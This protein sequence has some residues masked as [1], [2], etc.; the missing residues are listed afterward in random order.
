MKTKLIISLLI[1]LCVACQS[2]DDNPT[3]PATQTSSILIENQQVSGTIETKGNVDWYQYRTRRANSLLHIQCTNNTLRPDTELLVTAYKKNPDNTY[4]RLYADHAPENSVLPTNIQMSL[5]VKHPQDIYLAVRDYMDDDTSI[6][7]YYLKVSESEISTTKGDIATASPITVDNPDDCANAVI[8]SI[9]HFDH[10]R[11]SIMYRGVYEIQITPQTFQN[12]TSVVFCVDIYN[13][14][15]VLVARH[16]PFHNYITCLPLLLSAGDYQMVISDSGH[17]HADPS[18]SCKICIQS[19]S[20][21]E[22][23]MNDSQDQPAH[24]GSINSGQINI[25]GRIAYLKDQDCYA[26]ELT[27]TNDQELAVVKLSFQSLVSH[28]GAYQIDYYDTNRRIRSHEYTPGS[29]AYKTFMNIHTLENTLCVQAIETDQCDP[30]DYTA[31]LTLEWVDDPDE[32]EEKQN[33]FT[34]EWTQGNNTIETARIY[35]VD[36]VTSTMTGKIAYQG[37][38]DWYALAVNTSTQASVLNVFFQT[39]TAGAIEYRLSMRTDSIPIRQLLA[40]NPAQDTAFLKTSVWLPENT[41]EQFFL[42]V[43]DDLGDDADPYQTYE[44]VTHIVPTPIAIEPVNPGIFTHYH[45]ESMEIKTHTVS[46]Q[47]YDHTTQTFNVDTLSLRVNNPLAITKLDQNTVSIEYPWIG[48]YIDYQ[49]DHDFFL[50]TLNS[51]NVEALS[52]SNR[53]DTNQ[54]YYDISIDFKSL[55]S[56]VEYVWKLFRNSSGNQ[57]L[58]DRQNSSN[59]FFASAGDTSLQ[60]QAFDMHHPEADQKFWVNNRWAGQFYLCI[61]DFNNTTGDLPDDDWGYDAPYYFKLRLVYH[62]GEVSP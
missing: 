39:Q 31:K 48:G 34:G 25:E 13:S 33:Q 19:R 53:F 61:T 8:P 47:L 59:G 23:A 50:L 26:I 38:E 58:L 12:T 52:L 4:E 17:D 62:P 22:L 54:W 49:G 3:S 5:Y 16:K 15:G 20:E 30:M 44:I 40:G 42:R 14:A 29:S 43:C 32:T 18:A 27:T 57:Q 37:D 21:L 56:S 11:F 6:Y 28:Q 35:N 46:L 55:G 24:L 36:D 7:P 45:H 60:T 9:G 2:S 41:Q 1:C 51:S 10:F